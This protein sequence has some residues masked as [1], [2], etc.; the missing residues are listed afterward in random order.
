MLPR[1]ILL[2]MIVPALEL[3]VLLEVH[4][5][6][7]SRWG[8]GTGLL[9]TLGSILLSGV[10]GASLARRQGLATI[11]ALR[12][13]TSRGASPAVPLVDGA[14]ILA[15]AMLLLVPGL[16]TDLAGLSMLVP[17]SRRRYRRAVLR[18]FERK[19]GRGEAAFRVYGGGPVGPFGVGPDG[20]PLIDVT[21]ADE[22]SGPGADPSTNGS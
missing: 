7:A 3:W 22:L 20:G 12:D 21:P 17:W 11:R 10:A 13:A 14:L 6:I 5:A 15:G 8:S 16:L 4:R 1:L 19:V 18:W 2:L 9:A